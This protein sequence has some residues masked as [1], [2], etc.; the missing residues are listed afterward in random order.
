MAAATLWGIQ[1]LCA[2]GFRVPIP[3][4]EQAGGWEGGAFGNYY[5]KHIP[6]KALLAAAGVEQAAFDEGAVLYWAP[7]L[8]FLTDVTDTLEDAALPFLPMFRKFQAK[9][10]ALSDAICSN[11]KR[12]LSVAHA[13]QAAAGYPHDA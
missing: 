1:L 2:V 6:L 8:L 11:G 13:L 9:V 3:D 4:I 7:R 10:C 5:L 12:E